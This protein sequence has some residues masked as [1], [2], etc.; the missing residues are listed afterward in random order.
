[1]Q[2]ALEY[3]QTDDTFVLSALGSPDG[4]GLQRL[5]EMC[6]GSISTQV[7]NMSSNFHALL[8]DHEQ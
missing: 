7:Y 8:S 5:H 4:T 2:Y 3:M 1:M 6:E